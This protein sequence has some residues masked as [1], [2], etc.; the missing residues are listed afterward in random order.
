MRIELPAA[1]PPATAWRRPDQSLTLTFGPDA[2]TATEAPADPS[3]HG[4]CG[5]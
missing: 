4:R 1:P 2:G 5:R 3:P